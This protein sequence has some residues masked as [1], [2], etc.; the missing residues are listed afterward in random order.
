MSIAVVVQAGDELADGLFGDTEEGS[1]FNLIVVAPFQ[2]EKEEVFAGIGK[3]IFDGK[4]R[5]GFRQ[6]SQGLMMVRAVLEKESSWLKNVGA[7][8]EDGAFQHVG[9]LA[10]IA[11]PGVVLEGPKS[12][13][14]EL[15]GALAALVD[16][17]EEAE[18]EL[19]NLRAAITKS[20][21]TD[22]ND[23]EAEVEVFAET[24]ILHFLFEVAIGGSNDADVDLAGTRAADALDDA[25]LN[26]AKELGLD[27]ER[28]FGDFVEE[29]GAAISVFEEAGFVGGSSGESALGMT[30]QVGFG[31][32]F[33]NGGAVDGDDVLGGARAE[34]MDEMSEAF[35]T[36]AGFSGEED[37]ERGFGGDGGLFGGIAEMGGA[38]V[39][40]EFEEGVVEG[41]TRN[42]LANDGFVQYASGM[43]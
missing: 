29:E 19:R 16:L 20:R 31:E 9:E 28:K 14:G 33:G 15:T 11:G 18:G 37:R 17:L 41:R 10:D 8:I 39:E 34:A 7:G 43:G 36:G 38:D 42:I 25:V 13:F 6:K 32:R 12:V 30:E 40:V 3:E 35:F 26:D 2:G 1:G 27:V 22:L 21:E 4:A 23:F 24:F 5:S